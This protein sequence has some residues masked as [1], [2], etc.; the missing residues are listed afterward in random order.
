MIKCPCPHCHAGLK[1]PVEKA[2]TT[3]LCPRCKQRFMVPTA[4]ELEA[5]AQSAR[6]L[7]VTANLRE[8][9]SPWEQYRPGAGG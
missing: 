6:N 1:V 8:K 4:A 5:D 9:G 7:S 2:G 3:V